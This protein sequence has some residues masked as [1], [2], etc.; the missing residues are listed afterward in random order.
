M[1][2]ALIFLFKTLA[3]LYLLTFLLRFIMQWVR[4]S[5]YNPLSQFVFKVTNPLVV[6]ARRVLPSVAGLD[7]PTLVVLIALELV[8]TFVLSRSAASRC[9]S[10]SCSS[11]RCCD[12]SRS[13]LWFYIGALFIYVVLSWFGD[14]GAIRSVRARRSRRADIASGAPP[15]AADRRPRPFAA[16]VICAVQ[17]AMIALP[18]PATFARQVSCTRVM[19]IVLHNDHRRTTGVGDMVIS[20]RSHAGLPRSRSRDGGLRADGRRRP[21]QHAGRRLAGDRKQQGFRRVRALLQRAEHGPASPDIAREYGIVR[22][23]SRACSTSAFAASSTT[24]QTEAVT[25]A[26]SASAINLNGQLK[27]MTL[28]EIREDTGHLLHRRA[29]DHRRRSA[30]LYDRRHAD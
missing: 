16:L 19:S 1:Q 30:H 29:R 15:A 10:L 17:A 8:V 23:K 6:P 11:T 21:H 14:R 26:V 2:S 7:T 28:R 13:M 12:S 18:F 20:T 24:V 25:G 5:H 27:T 22:S 3:D 4:A 9:R